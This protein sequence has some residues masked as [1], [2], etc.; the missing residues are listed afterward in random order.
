MDFISHCIKRNPNKLEGRATAGMLII[1][2]VLS[3]LGWIYLTQA[4]HVATT[5]RRNQ[6]LEAEKTRLQQENM[7]LMVE[8][9][10]Y[11]SVSRLAARAHELGYVTVAPE[12][13]EFLAVAAPYPSL[14]LSGQAGYETSDGVVYARVDAG[15]A[16]IDAGYARIDAGHARTPDRWADGGGGAGS[17]AGSGSSWAP[18]A[19]LGG[20]KSQ[21]T[22]WVRE[23]TQ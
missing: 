9:A 21:F 15:Y 18:S 10:T 6:E 3:L 7:E 1:F 13:A 5:S 2:L 17:T 12:D 23:E 14:S 22:A 4:S 20:V 11:E 8:I 19:L 16:R